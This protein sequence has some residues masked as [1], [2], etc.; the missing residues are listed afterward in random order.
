MTSRNYISEEYTRF[1]VNR[2]KSYF[3]HDG[4]RAMS[5]DLD[6]GGK[7]IISCG[8][9]GMSGSFAVSSTTQ[10]TTKDNGAV[11]IEGGVGIEKN[12]NIGGSAG[13]TSSLSVSGN[14]T[15]TTITISGL[16]SLLSDLSVS[17]A[18][19]LNSDLTVDG[20]TTME[21]LTTNGL[22]NCTDTTESTVVGNG[23][24]VV[25]G[26]LGVAKNVNVG[27]SIN[28]QHNMVIS[29]LLD[30][31]G[32]TTISNTLG[33]AGTTN[34]L[35]ALNV[36]GLVRTTNVTQADSYTTGSVVTTGGVGIGKNLHVG[37]FIY[38]KGYMIMPIASVM[39]YSGSTSP[40]GWF[41]C[42]G[43]AYSRTT[44][45]LLFDIIGVVYGSGDGST[46]FNVPNLK[47]R[48]V[49]KNPNMI[50]I[51]HGGDLSPERGWGT[52]LIKSGP[53]TTGTTTIS[54]GI[55]GVGSGSADITVVNPLETV[56]TQF[57][58]PTGG[59][60]IIFNNDGLTS[61]F[62]ITFDESDRPTNTQSEVKYTL[63]P[64]NNLVSI[65]THSGFTEINFASSDFR[66]ELEIGKALLA[67]NPVGV[68]SLD[69]LQNFAV[70]RA[71]ADEGVEFHRREQFE[72]YTIVIC[73]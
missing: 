2:D 52:I 63:K 47:G 67:A 10:S 66:E 16:A 41:L 7:D 8:D 56:S 70:L 18:T 42:D 71:E 23:A 13:I 61:I 26:G 25:H 44:Y 49:S 21:A 72:S 19:T 4:T 69:K 32:A 24:V 50:K 48:V 39:S 17:G 51:L 33:V 29:G 9:F 62:L 12:I 40:D 20:D 27:G 22:I 14:T 65:P 55:T 73:P 35:S 28:L 31:A 3:L 60:S 34:L 1:V 57:F 53:L 58:S 6:M 54:A 38:Q 68:D 64:I 15:L 43:T 46:T 59:N 37:G 45:S 5:G 36:S 11:V 30:V